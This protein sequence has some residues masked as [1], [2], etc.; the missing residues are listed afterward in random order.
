M[1]KGSSACLGRLGLRVLVLAHCPEVTP[2]GGLWGCHDIPGSDLL[3]LGGFFSGAFLWAS[4]RAW[5]Q[6]P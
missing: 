4:M 2:A 5:V 3:F 6:A 1:L